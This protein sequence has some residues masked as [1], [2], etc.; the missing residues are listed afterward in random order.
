MGHRFCVFGKCIYQKQTQVSIW[1]L[2]Q[3]NNCYVDKQAS[4]DGVTIAQ[5]THA[6]VVAYQPG[7]C[8]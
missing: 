7:P 8:H 1:P 2:L 4:M 3:D 5:V 6:V